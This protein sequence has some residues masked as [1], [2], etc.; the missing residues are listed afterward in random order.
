LRIGG[1]TAMTSLD[2]PGELSAVVFCQ[3]CPW[4]C[5]Y[6]HNGPLLPRSQTTAI[7]WSDIEALLARRSG[8]LDAVV[9]SGGEPTSQNPLVAA[10]RRVKEKGFKVGLHTA[11]CHPNRLRGLTRFVDWVGLDIKALP[12]DYP[13][14]TGMP[15]SGARAWD[16]LRILLE[17]GVDLEVRTTPLPGW[18]LAEDIEPLM[19]RIAETGAT[20]YVVQTCR[21]AQTLDPAL[22]G[23]GTPLPETEALL[24]IG[25]GLFKHFSIRPPGSPGIGGYAR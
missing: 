22:T 14:I 7:P 18:R 25:R 20:N 2:Y 10:M 15:D 3:G 23:A 4:R 21:T 11:G 19:R 13:P 6:C 1:L 17:L 24:R 9:F 16:S 5:R 8:L 12:E